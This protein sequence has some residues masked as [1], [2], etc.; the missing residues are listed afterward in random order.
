MKLC[1]IAD[2]NN[3]THRGQCT[4]QDARAST[5]IRCTPPGARSCCTTRAQWAGERFVQLWQDVIGTVVRVAGEHDRE[6]LKRQRVLN[7]LLVMLCVFRRVHR[8]LL[9]QAPADRLGRL[10][11]GCR[12]FAVDGSKLNLPRPPVAAGYATPSPAAHYPQGLLR[13]LY[14]APTCRST[15]TWTLTATFCS[16]S[17]PRCSRRSVASSRCRPTRIPPRRRPCA[18][19]VRPAGAHGAV[20]LRGGRSDPH[21]R[22]QCRG[23]ADGH[24]RGGPRLGRVPYRDAFRQ[25]AAAVPAR[26]GLLRQGPAAQEDPTAPARAAWRGCCAWQR[27]RYSA[28][29]ARWE[30]SSVARQATRATRS[31]GLRPGAEA[32]DPHLPHAALRRGLPGYRRA[33]LRVAFPP[34]A[35]RRS[36]RRRQVARIRTRRVDRPSCVKRGEISPSHRS[37]TSYRWRSLACSRS[38]RAIRTA[39]TT[40]RGLA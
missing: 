22:H 34:P 32:G 11:H 27:L 20:A 39:A 18:V 38:V 31:A 23:V 19:A 29:A 7:T 33:S 10:W 1:I 30:R 40:H 21:R 26:G 24:H 14:S 2:T 16:I 37:V 4:G 35:P 12:V 6:W 9:E 17:S 5:Y 25:L 36:W 3:E 28:R 13:S 15:S 8:A